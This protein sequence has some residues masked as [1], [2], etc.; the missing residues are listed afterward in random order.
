MSFNR[1]LFFIAVLGISGYFYYDRVYKPMSGTSD[2]AVKSATKNPSAPDNPDKPE[3]PPKPPKPFYKWA[4]DKGTIHYTDDE[5][6]IPEK[7][8]DSASDVMLPEVT[9]LDNKTFNPG[10]IDFDTKE[11]EPPR[12]P[13]ISTARRVILYYI[14]SC[15]KCQKTHAL[16]KK[17]GVPYADIN[18]EK[19]PRGLR[20]LQQL[21]GGSAV[22]PVMEVGGRTI[23]GYRPEDIAQAVKSLKTK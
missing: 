20:A 3:A 2:A 8:R 21:T 5:A 7:F 23:V 13:N 18:V 9:V 14:P 11:P 6:A 1:L 15:P 19:D 17:L 22:V 16:L 10:S 12:T 4:D